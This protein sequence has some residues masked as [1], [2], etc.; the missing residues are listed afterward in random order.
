MGAVTDAER[1]IL[2]EAVVTAHRERDP[3]GGLKASPAFH[4]LD[5]E[6]R[7]RA[8]E[9]AIEQRAIEAAHDAAGRSTTVRSVLRMLNRP[10]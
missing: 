8:F 1:E 5:D 2:I 9:Q 7:L 10:R 6:G 4:D 3:R